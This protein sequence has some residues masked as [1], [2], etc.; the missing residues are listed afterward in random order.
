M[1]ATE[2]I[3]A[4]PASGSAPL[5]RVRGAKKSFGA[6]R[7]LDGVDLD[8]AAGEVT[9]LVGDNGAGKS[10]LIKAISGVDPPDAGSM[11]W[12]GEPIHIR[13]PT[14]AQRIGIATVFQDLALCDNLD[15]V[16]NLFLGR[17]LTRGGRLD[18]IGMEK[19]SRELLEELSVTTIQDVRAPV[20]L[21]SGG[22]RQSVAIA[23]SLLGEP[24]VVLLDEPT[25]ALG[26]AQTAEVLSLVERLRDR[27]FGVVL[28]SH[29]M[30]DVFAVSDRI[31]VLRLGQNAG[32]FETAQTT[33]EGIVSAIT[34]ADINAV[35]RR[36]AARVRREESQ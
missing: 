32:V 35:T 24:R 5:L 28:I 33:P 2:T 31:A 29:S 12:D 36:E 27:G 21:M 30:P 11:E 19:R 6:V 18:E 23:R 1:S 20:G 8:V 17:E 13:R 4:G 10:V 25:A 14:D 9:A 34:G 16:A 26:V 3:E 15:L 22:Q 7:A